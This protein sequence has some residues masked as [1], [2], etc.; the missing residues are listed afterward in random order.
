MNFLSFP[1][2]YLGYQRPSTFISLVSQISPRIIDCAVARS[3]VTMVGRA[4]VVKKEAQI[5]LLTASVRLLR[6]VVILVL[7]LYQISS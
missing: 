5:R 3:S 1:F 6:R 4:F 7:G 2:N